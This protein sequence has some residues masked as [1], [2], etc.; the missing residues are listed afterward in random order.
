MDDNIQYLSWV[1]DLYSDLKKG[2]QDNVQYNLT[3]S[4]MA[5]PT[6]LISSHLRLGVS[7][8][9]LRMPD[10]WYPL[11]LSRQIASWEGVRPENILP[12]NGASGALFL[13]CRS[14]LEKG[15]H[16]IVEHP[17]YEPLFAVPKFM[18]AD[19][20]F[21]QRK[22][23]NQYRVDPDEL[24]A[25][26]SARTKLIILTNTHNPTGARMSGQELKRI[27]GIAKKRNRNVRILVDEVYHRFV[28]EDCKSAATLDDGFISINSLS[29]V[30]GLWILRCGWIVA[31]PD[32]IKRFLKIFVLTENVGSPLN[33][34]V[35][36][37]VFQH[38]KDYED[39]SRDLLSQNRLIL[40]ETMNPLLEEAFIEGDIP[41]HGCIYFPKL[42][43][44]EDTRTFTQSL[45]KNQDVFMTPG[46]FFGAP[47][48]IR[49]G[50]GCQS[51]SLRE[52][53]KKFDSAIRKKRPYST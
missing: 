28:E 6:E 12:T 33:E 39:Y 22:V 34:S 43:G 50:F 53:L 46:Y 3:A 23:E 21:L 26:V 44:M 7:Q 29:K 48:H 4:A 20:S 16:V 8:E 5:E 17:Y 10:P 2:N 41:E 51:E 13:V 36:N 31:E 25:L 19:I 32:L 27:L 30:F 11:H 42:A 18:G 47:R 38:M 37:L 49:I 24:D 52:G 40:Q 15:D 1:K 9:Y 35:S 45:S 14:I